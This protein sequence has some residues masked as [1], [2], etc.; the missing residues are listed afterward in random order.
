MEAWEWVDSDYDRDEL[1]KLKE[2]G[3]KYLI[4]ECEL[5]KHRELLTRYKREPKPQE[6]K[7]AGR[8]RKK[9]VFSWED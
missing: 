7:R 2:K 1:E 6:K 4:E 3:G 5:T 8:K 9:R